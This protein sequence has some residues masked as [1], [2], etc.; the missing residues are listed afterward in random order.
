MILD[1]IIVTL[2]VFL[3]TKYLA[4][5]SNSGFALRIA[6]FLAIP[7]T[8]LLILFALIVVISVTEILA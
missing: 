7:I 1:I 8:S 3:A 2:A 5:A 4:G 6:R